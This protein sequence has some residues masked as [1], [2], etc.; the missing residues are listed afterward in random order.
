MYFSGQLN[1]FPVR[2]HPN[3]IR[4]PKTHSR[5]Q[6]IQ[7]RTLKHKLGEL[8]KP[9]VSQ[10]HDL[11][12]LFPNQDSIRMDESISSISSKKVQTE[13]DKDLISIVQQMEALSNARYV[14]LKKEAD[15]AGHLLPRVCEDRGVMENE[16]ECDDSVHPLTWIWHLHPCQLPVGRLMAGS[17]AAC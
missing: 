17:V 16:N 12:T 4:K 14:D 8:T 6:R 13:G 1:W 5:L 11:V 10:A 7:K 2:P 9:V 3:R 15:I